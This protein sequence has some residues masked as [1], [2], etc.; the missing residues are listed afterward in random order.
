MKKMTGKTSAKRRNYLSFM[1]VPHNKGTVHT[2]RINNYRTTLLSI[3]A[4]ML[5]ALLMLTGF[6]LSVVNEN[7]SLKV[8]HARELEAIVA[9]K[10]QLEDYIANQTQQ[11]IENTELISAASS[12]RSQTDKAISKLTSEYEDMVVSYVDNNMQSI[13]KVSRGASS[14]ATFKD[15]LSELRSL[16]DV[17]KSAKLAEDDVSSQI[18]KKETELTNYLNSLPTKWPLD[19]VVSVASNFGRRL[20]PIYHRYIDHDGIDIGSVKNSP[21]YASGAGKVIHAGWNGGYGNCV[22]IDHGNGFESVYGHLNSYSVKVGDWVKKGQQIAKMG[23]T[24]TSTSAHL[25]YE[26][27]INDTPTDPKKYLEY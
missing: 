27:R 1:F 3:T 10:E 21:I 16:I 9:Q 6:T 19:E 26:L 4:I 23:N 7:K 8:E 18:A 20:H 12:S 5:V 25:H 22:I 2:I 15:G 13:K 24:G 14:G 17:V 11:L